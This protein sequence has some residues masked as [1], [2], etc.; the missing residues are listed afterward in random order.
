MIKWRQGVIYG[1][2]RIHE[3]DFIK[4]DILV[5]TIKE[6]TQTGKFFKDLDHLI[7]LHQGMKF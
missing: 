5:P 1:Q 7:T 3:S 4:I 2:W 6:Q